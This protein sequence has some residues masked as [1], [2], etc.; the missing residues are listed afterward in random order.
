ML[1]AVVDFNHT[2]WGGRT[3]P[4]IFFSG[5]S[6]AEDD[7]RHLELADVDCVQAFSP[8]PSKLVE[9]LDDRLGPWSI[10][11]QDVTKNSNTAVHVECYYTVPVPPT[12]ENVRQFSGEKFL[13]FEFTPDCEVV[14][15]QFVHRNFGTFH[16][17]INGKN[18]A[19]RL[20]GLER[21]LPQIEV[22]TLRISD[23]QSLA[24]AICEM[25]GDPPGHGSRRPLS[26]IAPSQLPFA[27]V[28]KM[29]SGTA[30]RDVYQIIVGDEPADFSEHWNGARWKGV[31]PD[32]F[33]HQLWLPSVLA[34][35]ATVRESLTNWLA[36]FT[37][38]G[39]SENRRV[40]FLSTSWK[41]DALEDLRAAV[42]EGKVRLPSECLKVDQ[43]AE[44]RQKAQAT[45]ASARPAALLTQTADAIRYTANS[46]QET[47]TLGKPDILSDESN[48]DGGWMVDV[49][50]EQMSRHV[51][52]AREQH[53]W[54]MPRRNAGGF[55]QTFHG[56]ARVNRHGT[57]SVYVERRS[58]WTVQRQ[59]ELRLGLPPQSAVVP[60]LITEPYI[61]P[62]FNSDFRCKALQRKPQI[63]RIQ[64]SDKGNYLRGLIDMF[65]NF[66]TAKTFCERRFWQHLLRKLANRDARTDAKLQEQIQNILQGEFAGAAGVVGEQAERA[67]EKI[68]R[69]VGSR[70]AG[71]RL[72]FEQC[73]KQLEKLAKE[74][75]LQSLSYPQGDTIVQRN[76]TASLTEAEMKE[77]LDQ[78]LEAGVLRLGVESRCH[79]C[80]VPTWYHVDDLRQIVVC[81]GCGSSHT[82]TAKEDWSYSL[83]SLV[84]VGI[85]Q[86]VLGVLQALSELATGFASSFVFSPNLE[87]LRP[88]DQRPWHEID[89]ACVVN[90]EF[91]VGEV[92]EGRFS[93]A[94]FDELAE[95]AEVLRPQRAVM[96]IPHDK[97]NAQV[98]SWRQKMQT[99]L[100]PHGIKAELYT[101]PIF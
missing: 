10:E 24:A 36:R 84:Q 53:W 87:L 19:R 44:Q 31:W 96:F 99:R 26:F 4:I 92:K 71:R 69:R 12:R 56:A 23:R 48:P 3:N 43:L 90:G 83:N 77:G 32:V 55:L 14:I 6:L 64:I 74:P 8:L 70:L 46:Q 101:L 35:E 51:S 2:K 7:W 97:N 66:W 67:A 76:D 50:I 60:L 80:G 65:G 62:A 33:A 22:Q 15:Q 28:P 61:R 5:E 18:V 1:N 40:E 16:Q 37:G 13:M 86:G 59:T 95:I 68:L 54:L 38:Y 100:S 42:C 85:S 39:S 79:Q 34:A 91:I 98:E 47:L 88:S 63:S 82:L 52:G 25:A 45:L 21:L 29:W 72:T 27:R 9:E 57:F 17:W 89:V 78:L 30:S 11:V 58:G 75:Q 93:E 94:D 73:R 49:Q 41:P 81:P 20:A